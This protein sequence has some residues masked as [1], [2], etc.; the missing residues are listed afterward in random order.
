MRR[1]WAAL[2]RRRHDAQRLAILG[3]VALPVLLAL[4]T[5]HEPA[6]TDEATFATIARGLA[7][8]KLLYRDL[9]DHKPPVIYGW[10]A[11]NFALFGEFIEPVRLSIAATLATTTF[12]ML[13]LLKRLYSDAAAYIGA[14][15]FAVSTGFRP[16]L[17]DSDTER[18]MLL[19]M[20]GALLAFTAAVQ[21]GRHWLFLLAGVLGGIAALTK[22]VAAFSLL[23]LGVIA[24]A[25]GWQEARR[26]GRLKPAAYLTAGAA[27]ALVVALIPFVATGTV[28]DA[29]DAN[30]QFN[31]LYG[32]LPSTPERAAKMVSGAL[33]FA[34][35]WPPVFVAAVFGVFAL[36]RRRR[37]PEDHLILAWAIGSLAG[38]AAPGFFFSH[39][40]VQLLPATVL[41]AAAFID[42]QRMSFR[43]TRRELATLG[44]AGTLTGLALLPALAP[45]AYL[46]PDGADER[47]DWLEEIERVGAYLAVRTEPGDAVYLYGLAPQGYFHAD[48][49][50]TARYFF[51]VPF[52]VRPETLEE[53]IAALREDLPVYIVDAPRS[54]S[55]TYGQRVDGFPA[56]LR[57]EYELVEETGLARIYRRRD[58]P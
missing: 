6:S 16:L 30:I 50:P 20:V 54:G 26:R 2:A 38:V 23:A 1:T 22:P 56:L 55:I 11:A 32:A 57:D 43:G 5:L 35:L 34:A 14:A 29:I 52:D 19:P 9:F 36:A 13:V 39:Y 18:L 31:V 46:T 17:T 21:S 58:A 8:G 47:R 25:W 15:V 4:P 41:L 37:W 27:A 45:S 12:L 28:I 24:L 40:L 7:D 51:D 42:A 53:T 48:R 44:A 33:S 3:I 10:Y 49:L